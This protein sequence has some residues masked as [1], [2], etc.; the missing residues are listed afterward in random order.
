MCVFACICIKDL[1]KDA[2]GTKVGAQGARSWACWRSGMKGRLICEPLMGLPAQNLK[3]MFSSEQQIG[4]H[5]GQRQVEVTRENGDGTSRPGT[6]EEP[7]MTCMTLPSSS[8][9]DPQAC[10]LPGSG[11]GESSHEPVRH[12]YNPWVA[13]KDRLRG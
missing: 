6:T 12:H 13:D 2:Q 7:H 3:G 11:R 4:E 8:S 10:H 1:W 5:Y 9:H